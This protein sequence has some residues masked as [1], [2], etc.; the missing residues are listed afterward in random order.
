MQL[1]EINIARLKAPLDAPETK[2]FK[3]FLDPINTLAEESPG[4]IWRMTVEPP[5]HPWSHDPLIVLNMSVWTDLDSLRDY[6]FTTVHSYFLRSRAKWFHKLGHPNLAM[7][8]IEDGHLPTLTESRE[9]LDQLEK[10]GPG[11][12]CFTF[13]RTFPPL[14]G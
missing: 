10:E 3:D 5:D 6:A 7:W 1:A 11:E 9:R 4:F 12:R 8:W 13:A 2:E 14:P